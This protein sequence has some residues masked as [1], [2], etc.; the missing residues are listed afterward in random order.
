MNK[1]IKSIYMG[2]TCLLILAV[3]GCVTTAEMFQGGSVSPEQVFAIQETGPNKGYDQN[4]DIIISY[5]F[6]RSGDVLEISGQAV[7][8]DRYPKTY[9]SLN[10]LHVYLFF[11]D[12]SL[13]VLETVALASSMAGNLDEHFEFSQSLNIPTGAVGI[14]FGYDGEARG[15]GGRMASAYTFYRLP[16]KA[17][18]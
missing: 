3:A 14:S 16:L 8:T 18:R 7:L 10:Y 12:D 4:F 11:L 17:Q 2:C 1:K 5:E 15:G 9:E 6:V 13:R